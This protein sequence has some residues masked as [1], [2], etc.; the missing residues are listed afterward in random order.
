[1][2]EIKKNTVFLDARELK[3]FNVSHV[4]NAINVGF[5]NKDMEHLSKKWDKSI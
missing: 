1:V 2:E 3:E 5:E 4:E